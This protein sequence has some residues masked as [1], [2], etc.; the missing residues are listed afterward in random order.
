MEFVLVCN[1]NNMSINAEQIS[2]GTEAIQWK[3]TTKYK[4]YN[5]N[6]QQNIK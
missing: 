5:E 2:T 4:I 3:Q 6:K 1:Y